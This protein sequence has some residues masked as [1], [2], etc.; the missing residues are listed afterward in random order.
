MNLFKRVLAW[1]KRERGNLFSQ[2][3]GNI[4]V[5]KDRSVSGAEFYLDSERWIV[6]GMSDLKVVWSY[7]RAHTMTN[8][9]TGEKAKLNMNHISKIRKVT[10]NPV[11]N[12]VTS[13]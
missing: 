11:T 7:R 13:R 6:T 5:H 8:Q 9:L 3:K 1:E 2:L 12:E 4:Q 10:Y